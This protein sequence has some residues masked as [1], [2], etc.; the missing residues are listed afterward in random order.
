MFHVK[1]TYL[2][3]KNLNPIENDWMG[4]ITLGKAPGIEFSIFAHG[5]Y[6]DNP[7]FET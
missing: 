1:T 6:T 5:F 7:N 3:R 2:F 4:K